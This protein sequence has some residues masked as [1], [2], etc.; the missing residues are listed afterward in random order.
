MEP[1][2]GAPLVL[3]A[4]LFIFVFIY[5]FIFF[6]KTDAEINANSGE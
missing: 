3:T 2:H 6:A 1:S 4:H 5:L